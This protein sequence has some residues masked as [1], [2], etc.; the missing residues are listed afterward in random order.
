MARLEIGKHGRGQ[1]MIDVCRFMDIRVQVTPKKLYDFKHIRQK[2]LSL[3][4]RSMAYVIA[5]IYE[6]AKKLR[7]KLEEKNK[8]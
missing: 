5:T 3:K 6:C 7:R 1:A 2:F 8:F 4:N